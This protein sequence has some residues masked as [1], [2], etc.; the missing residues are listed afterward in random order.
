MKPVIKYVQKFVID[1]HLFTPVVRLA[2]FLRLP[3]SCFEIFQIYNIHETNR[4]ST[5]FLSDLK[6]LVAQT[7]CI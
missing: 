1:L 2:I 3:P 6:Y 4:K 5:I 7:E